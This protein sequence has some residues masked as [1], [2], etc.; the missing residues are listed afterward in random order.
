[1][2][3]TGAAGRVGHIVVPRLH[4]AWD[5]RL[6]DLAR[7]G[8]LPGEWVTGSVTDAGVMAGACR[9]VDAVIHL[10]ALAGEDSWDRLMAVN[11][12]GTRTVLDAALAAGVPRVVLASSVHT[13]GFRPAGQPVP[14]DCPPCP[15]TLY[16]VSKAAVEALGSLYH[17]RFGLDVIC[18]R[19]GSCF[20]RPVDRHALSLWLS[21]G[22]A[23]RMFEACLTATAP[24]F[25]V[26][27]GVSANSRGCC[28][29]R[30]G[31]ELG[32][33]PVDDAERFAAA[34]PPDETVSAHLGG[35][36]FTTTELGR[37]IGQG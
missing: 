9:G 35:R 15:D 17:F 29:L 36:L 16:G 24:G 19:I 23:G 20:V 3:V 28:S 13:V 6:L 12:S 22:D 8:D 1:M 31:R 34:V 2:L 33:H 27:W 21:P 32:Y 18:V 14:A 4:A 7:P 11:V 25:R 10:A 30:E 5:L 37:P 26:I